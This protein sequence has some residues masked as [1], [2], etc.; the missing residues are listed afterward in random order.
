MVL[1]YLDSGDNRLATGA[2]IFLLVTLGVWLLLV[3]LVAAYAERKGH[4]LVVFLLLGFF[5]SP[6]IAVVIA[7]LVEDKRV[8]PT[9]G[10][11]RDRAAQLADLAALRE[12]GALSTAE[13]DAEK[14][15]LLARE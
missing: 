1:G 7:L 5:L 11:E 6:L 13:Y 14:A 4:S 15:R 12:R 9:T 2:I 10:G 8:R 3:W